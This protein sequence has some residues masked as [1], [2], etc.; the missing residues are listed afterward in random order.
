MVNIVFP[1]SI[2]WKTN[3]D[4]LEDTDIFWWSLLEQ[5]FRL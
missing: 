2:D 1:C 4:L 5:D 3:D